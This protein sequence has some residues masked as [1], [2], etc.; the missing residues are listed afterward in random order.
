MCMF[1]RAPFV[2]LSADTHVRALKLIKPTQLK[3]SCYLAVG[4]EEVILWN[5]D[6][7]GQKAGL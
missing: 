5:T 7:F 6:H 2:C 1:L 4:A 3:A